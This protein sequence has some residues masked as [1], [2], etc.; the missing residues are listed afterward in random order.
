[1][2]TTAPQVTKRQ[3][4]ILGFLREGMR[5][6]SPTIRDICKHFGFRSPNGALCHI[7]ALERKGLIRRSGQ[8]RGY[9]VVE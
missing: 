5:P 4:E 9:E 6:A 7:V 2:T 1:M 3:A 8:A